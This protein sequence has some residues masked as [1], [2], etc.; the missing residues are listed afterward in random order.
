MHSNS[1]YSNYC[2][3]SI[4]PV[5]RVFLLHAA[6]FG[7][8]RGLLA[9]CA[10]H[11]PIGCGLARPG[12]ARP[13]KGATRMGSAGSWLRLDRLAASAR[14]CGHSIAASGAGVPG[15]PGRT[16]FERAGGGGSRRRCQGRRGLISPG[17]GQPATACALADAQAA[18]LL[19]ADGKPRGAARLRGPSGRRPLRRPSAPGAAACF[20]ACCRRVKAARTYGALLRRGWRNRD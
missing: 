18:G 12:P 6:A 2:A 4:Y 13:G 15:G 3:N 8:R 5:N 10:G 16:G 11:C 9:C 7:R 20:H 17:C 14:S 19:Q 1:W